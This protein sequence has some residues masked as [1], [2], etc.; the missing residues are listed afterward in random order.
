PDHCPGA[1]V[2]WTKTPAAMVPIEIQ[3]YTQIRLPVKIDGKEI[4][5]ILDTGAYTSVI[6]MRAAKR[7]L[8]L[9][10]KDPAMTSRQEV[11]NGMA[12]AVRTYPF[13]TLSFGDVQVNHPQIQ[14]VE[15]RVWDDRSDLLL[16]I[17]ILR[18]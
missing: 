1:V 17:G 12:G 13:Q 15:D 4:Y 2:Y 10:E 6:T 18:Q 16:G 5:A 7:Y 8:G 14:I 9:D 11:I 3:N